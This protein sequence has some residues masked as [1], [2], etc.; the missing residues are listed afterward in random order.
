MSPPFYAAGSPWAIRLFQSEVPPAF[1]TQDTIPFWD[2][3]RLRSSLSRVDVS[4]VNEKKSPGGQRQRAVRSCLPRCVICSPR[5]LKPREEGARLSN[6]LTFPFSNRYFT[7]LTSCRMTVIIFSAGDFCLRSHQK[8]RLVSAVPERG[9]LQ[10][11]QG[12]AL[13]W[14]AKLRHS[15]TDLERWV[16]CVD[17]TYYLR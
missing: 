10:V 8:R 17:M 14:M 3:R 4:D 6:F 2:V 7:S 13:S 9:H 12:C 1:G 11:Q 16:L 15:R 5:R